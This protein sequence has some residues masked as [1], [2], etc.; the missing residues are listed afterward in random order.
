MFEYVNK[1]YI[2]NNK[3]KK[4][5]LEYEK[6]EQEQKSYRLS[7][8]QIKNLGID[9]TNRKVELRKNISKIAADKFSLDYSKI[10]LKCNIGESAMRKYLKG[11]RNMSRAA[12]MRFC[13]GADITVEEA[14]ALFILFGHALDPKN[15]LVDAIVIDN[16]RCKEGIEVLYEECE[17]NGVLRDVFK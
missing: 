15:N 11:T 8:D 5:G 6:R 9:I 2:K 13:S 7:D 16:I 1:E 3:F 14:Q 4:T 12:L 10:D 17:K